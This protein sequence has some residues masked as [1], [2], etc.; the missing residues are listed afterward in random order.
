MDS[1]SGSER[2]V[3]GSGSERVVSGSGLERGGLFDRV[4]GG[5]GNWDEAD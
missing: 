5:R 4:E 3:S 2:V 1:G